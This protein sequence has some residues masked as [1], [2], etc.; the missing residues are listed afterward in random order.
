VPAQYCVAALA[1]V[2]DVGQG[3]EAGPQPVLRRGT[4]SSR[5]HTASHTVSCAML[6]KN[7]PDATFA[8]AVGPTLP[9][10]SPAL[11]AHTNPPHLLLATPSASTDATRSLSSTGFAS[12]SARQG[13]QAMTRARYSGAA[14]TGLSLRCKRWRRGQ[15]VKLCTSSWRERQLNERSRCRRAGQPERGGTRSMLTMREITPP[16]FSFSGRMRGLRGCTGCQQG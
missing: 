10:P 2:D 12:N 11:A 14:A 9:P 4:C 15:G 8:T 1:L 6:T 13:Q 5:T 3:A 7:T 16:I